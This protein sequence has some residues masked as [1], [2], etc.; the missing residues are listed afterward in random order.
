MYTIAL[1]NGDW[2][3]SNRHGRVITGRSK[4][5][6]CLTQWLVETRGI[7]RFHPTYG[8]QIQNMVG[9]QRTESNRLAV[10]KIVRQSCIDYMNYVSAEFEQHPDRYSKDE[11]IAQVLGVT[12]YYIEEEIHVTVA[13]RTLAGNVEEIGVD[14]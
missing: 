6:Q 5:T 13:V 3:F 14:V 2:D 1:K 11:V 8:S 4:L 9:M 7:D 12:S 10:E